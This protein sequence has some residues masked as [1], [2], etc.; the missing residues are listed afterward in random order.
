MIDILKVIDKRPKILIVSPALEKGGMER[1]LS[2]FLKA[3]DR[4]ILNIKVLFYRQRIDY[5]LPEDLEYH[6][7]NKK[8]VID[9][10]FVF[11]LIRFL[12]SEKWD[13]INS[14]IGG[15]YIL[16]FAGLRLLNPR[17]VIIEIRSSSVSRHYKISSLLIKFFLLKKVRIVCNSLKAKQEFSGYIKNEIYTIPN[18][19]DL[20]LFHK[21]QEIQKDEMAPFKIGYVGRINP[22]KNIETLLLAFKNVISKANIEV[23]LGIWGRV[24]DEK[25]FNRLKELIKQNKLEKVVQFHGQTSKVVDI[26]N[27][28]DLFVLPSHYEGTPNVLLEAM[29]CEVISIISQG[30]NSDNFLD[31]DFVF[32]TNNH[33]ELGAKIIKIMNLPLARK[34]EIGKMN[35]RFI[36]KNYS[37]GKMVNSYSELYQYLE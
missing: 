8:G 32:E 14:K 35:R 2:E 36:Q 26:Y 12:L 13:I 20:N 21:K 27:Q 18:G 28:L 6:T 31:E 9:I 1:Q 19:V 4:K 25:Y 34:N 3:Y 15:V 37:L 29:S 16:L 17:K 5:D 10:L 30:A 33:Q 24:Q 22:E 23:S 11:R 7:L